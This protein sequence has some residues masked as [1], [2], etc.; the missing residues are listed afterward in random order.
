MVEDLL[1]IDRVARESGFASSALRYYERFGLISVGLKIQ[2]K[3]HYAR[4]VLQ[5]L[6]VIKVCQS[7]GFSLTEIA[8]LLDGADQPDGAWRDLALRRRRDID[9]QI[10]LLHSLA[11]TLDVALNC[12]CA[13]L[14]QCPEM[15]PQGGVAS[16]ACHDRQELPDRW[17]GRS[18]GDV[19]LKDDR[20]TV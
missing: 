9:E 1:P 2:G 18:R 10:K 3:R 5:R 6:S 15:G 19:A 7:V 4:S 16:R 20:K 8:D 14:T 11:D 12:E 17:S 13:E